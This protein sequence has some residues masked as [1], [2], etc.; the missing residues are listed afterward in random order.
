MVSI[1]VFKMQGTSLVRA[2]GL[3]E[4][5]TSVQ[6]SEITEPYKCIK[7]ITATRLRY[8]YP[9]NLVVFKFSNLSFFKRMCLCL[10]NS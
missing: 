5:D 2:N 1:L 4:T 6:Y 3:I 9:D 8:F 7:Y 10:S